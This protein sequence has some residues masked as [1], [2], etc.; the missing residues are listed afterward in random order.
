MQND[1]SVDET[2][3]KPDIIL[4]YNES[5]AG[6][7]ALDQ[8]CSNSTS[9]STRRWPMA[10]FHMIL[11]VSGINSRVLY[12]FAT[13][14]KTISRLDFLKVLGRNLCEPH[15]KRRIY[16]NKIPRKLRDLTADILGVII[17]VQEVPQHPNGRDV[18]FAP[19]KKIARLTP[20][21]IPANYRC[22][23]CFKK[24]CPNCI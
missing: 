10:I 13:D 6:V 11:N 19:Q 7:D 5:K 2:T 3:K 21:A 1:N 12:Q 4:F 23:Q 9:R 18:L 16:N 15:M 8:K 17:E 22:Q 20:F 14:G 24:I